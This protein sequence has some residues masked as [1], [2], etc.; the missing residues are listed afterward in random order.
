VPLLLSFLI[1]LPGGHLGEPVIADPHHGRDDAAS[2]AS[3]NS[4]TNALERLDHQLPGDVVVRGAHLNG[5]SSPDRPVPGPIRNGLARGT[6][7]ATM[8]P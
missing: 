8:R 3:A 1:T 5:A 2:S 6:G 7:W 4:D